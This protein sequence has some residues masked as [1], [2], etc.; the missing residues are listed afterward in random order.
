MKINLALAFLSFGTILLHSNI[1]GAEDHLYLVNGD[2]LSG[3][4]TGYQGGHVTISTE[5]GLLSIP[6]AKI[7]GT[8]SNTLQKELLPSITEANV[9]PQNKVDSQ[10]A[11]ETPVTLNT[12]E[13]DVAPV[14]QIL[15]EETD[16]RLWGAEWSGAVNLGASLERGNSDTETIN[17]DAET[18]ARWENDRLSFEAEYNRAKENGTL[19]EDDKAVSAAYDRFLTDKIFWENAISL[20]QDEIDLIDLRIIYSSGLGYQF[21]DRDDLTLKTVA[22]IGYIREDFDD[23]PT[24]SAMTLNWSADY[25]QKFYED[26]FRLFHKHDINTP[27]D[28]FSAFLFQSESGIKIPLRYGIVSSLQVDF[29]WDNSPAPGTTEEDTNYILKLGYEW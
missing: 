5:Y 15:S 16:D 13:T 3:E 12:V 8:S 14:E 10:I 28:D 9:T 27:V 2:R 21:F 17:F 6:Y 7:H 19:S 4:V 23:S 25:T 24:E 20:Q 29:D 22:G 18:T 26:F 11:A 1:A